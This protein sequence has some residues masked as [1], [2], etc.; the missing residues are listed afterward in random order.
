MQNA[1]T[2]SPGLRSLPSGAERTTP[3]TSLPGTN[4]SGGLTWYS[5]RVWSTSGNDTPAACTSTSTDESGAIGCEVGSSTSSRRRAESGPVSSV[6][7]RARMARQSIRAPRFRTRRRDDAAARA[8]SA[9][10][11]LDLAL[12]DLARGALGQVVDE[13]DLARVLVRGH[14]LLHESAQ[15][16]RRHLL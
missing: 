4:G 3:P 15:L 5:P 6:I 14:A 2:R 9:V 16:V 13:P 1:A 10:R 12:E 7:W 11:R 8:G